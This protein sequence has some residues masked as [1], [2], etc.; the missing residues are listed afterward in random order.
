ML[1]NG[2]S[3]QCSE[4]ETASLVVFYVFTFTKNF[5]SKQYKF[6]TNKYF[7]IAFNMWKFVP[8]NYDSRTALIFYY[9]LKN[10]AAECLSKFTLA[11]GKSQYFIGLKN[12]KV[13]ILTWE[14]K[15]VEDHRK[16]LE[17]PNRK[18]CWMRMTL[19]RNKNS[20][21]N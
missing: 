2:N 17:T 10:T 1:I 6:N 3:W 5:N 14:K 9:H 4:Y 13:A 11:L 21:I 16:S 7:F 18:H 15:N 12:S 19:K 8:K 20:Q